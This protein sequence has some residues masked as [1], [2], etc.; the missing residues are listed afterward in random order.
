LQ[1][2]EREKDEY[3]GKGNINSQRNSTTIA[4][5]SPI[6]GSINTS[7]Q[8]TPITIQTKVTFRLVL[9]RSQQQ[10]QTQSKIKFYHIVAHTTT[11]NIEPIV[12]IID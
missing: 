12:Q 3:N 7:T 1:E 8:A 6:N 5:T 9:F 11:I 2:E 4:Y 10:Q